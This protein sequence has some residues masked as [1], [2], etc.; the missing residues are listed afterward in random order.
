MDAGFIH[1][2]EIGQYFMTKDTENSSLRGLVANTLFQEVTNHHNQEDG[3]RETQELD[4]YWKSRPV[5]CTLNM[6]LKSGSGL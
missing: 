3:F 5:T 1:V 4:P 2:V 6:E